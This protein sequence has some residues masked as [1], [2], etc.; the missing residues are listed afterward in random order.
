MNSVVLLLTGIILFLIAYL[1]YGRWLA[2]HWGIDISKQTPAHTKF[3]N[4][5]YCPADAKILLGHHF[6]SIAGAGPIAGPIQASIFGWVP[7]MLW[8]V[9]GS[10][11]IGGVHDFGSLFASIRH[12]GNSIGEIIRV[13]IGEKGKK[14]FNIFAWVTLVLVVAAFTDICASTFAYNP[15]TPELLTGARSG[16]ASILFI[17]LAMGFGFFVY[18]RNAPVGLSTVVGVA[19]L[20]FCIYIGYRFPVLKLSKFQWQIVLLIYITAASTMPVWLLLQPRDYLCSFLLYAM[21]IGAFI[22]ILVLH[23]TMQLEATTSFTVKGQTLFPFLFVTVACGAV[24][25]FHSLVSSGTSSKQLNSEKDTQLIGYGSMLIEGVVAIIALIAVGYVAKAKGTPAEVFANGCAAF[26]NSFGIPLAIGKVFVTLSF[27]A[28]ALTSLDTAT[29]IG[30]YIFQEFFQGS[31]EKEGEKK[32]VFTNMYVSTLITVFCALGLLLYGYEKIW[33]IFGSA[34]QLLAALALLSLTAWLSRRG[35]KTIM[36]IIPMIFMFAVTLSALF[37]IIKSYLFG[38]KPNYILGVMA[39]ILLV[40]AVI[41]A[42]E[43]YN[44]L[45]KNKKANTNLGA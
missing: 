4:V 6:S 38:A 28:F 34:N 2:K 13:N 33:P 16:T 10:I 41:L 32:S 40:L 22:G 27:S 39:V 36:I 21:L 9:I 42:V 1:T 23:P 15:Q 43:A 8:I 11:F 25:G 29:R 20:F 12:G 30:R 45:N 44:T 14:L 26:M 35:K 24:S 19:L 3:D 31:N 18:R 7:V 17:F 37:L 5:D